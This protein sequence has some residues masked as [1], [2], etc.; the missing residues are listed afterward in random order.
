MPDASRSACMATAL[1]TSTSQAAAM[2][3]EFIS[4]SRTQ[5]ET[6]SHGFFFKPDG[7]GGGMLG[8]PVRLEGAAW[9]HLRYGS[10]KVSWLAVSPSLELSPRGAL[11]AND[12]ASREDGC[13]VSCVDWYGN[14][15]PI[16]Y[17]DRVFAL[18]GYELV[19]GGLGAGGVEELARTDFLLGP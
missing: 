11:A 10:A 4:L 6:R 5:G 7:T 16:F 18:L 3:R 2:W 14:A 13:A 9:E 17:R 15:R 19:E 1:P 8:L 12:G